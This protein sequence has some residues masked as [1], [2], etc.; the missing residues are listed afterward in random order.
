MRASLVVS[1]VISTIAQQSGGVL[2]EA[3]AWGVP[4]LRGG[5]AGVADRAAMFSLSWTF[6]FTSV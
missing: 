5:G 1:A 2:V 3:A 4:S 6:A